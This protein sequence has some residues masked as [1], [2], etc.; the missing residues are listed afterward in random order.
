[1]AGNTD[2]DRTAGTPILRAE[3]YPIS[4]KYLK[5][6]T[7][8]IGG[9]EDAAHYL[10]L[11]LIGDDGATGAAEVICKPAWNGVTQGVLVKMFEEMAWPALVQEGLKNAHAGAAIAARF[12]GATAL[13]S[14]LDNACRDLY[15]AQAGE[16][17]APGGSWIAAAVLLTRDTPANMAGSAAK[18]VHELGYRAV[19]IK[20]GQGVETD[21]EVFSQIRQAVGG[22]IRLSID[23][24][25]AYS[26]EDAIRLAEI[27]QQIGAIFLED[28]CALVPSN[29]F[30][31][32]LNA[33]P[34]AIL[35]D[36]SCASIEQAQSFSDL[37]ASYFSAKPNR[38]GRREAEK[39]A[40]LA[41]AKGG[42]ICVGM[43]GESAAGAVTQLQLAS[44]FCAAQDALETEAGFH[45]DLSDNYLIEPLEFADGRFKLPPKKLAE[46]IDWA[47]LAAM[48]H[49]VIALDDGGN[50]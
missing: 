34:L 7:W 19:K 9:E 39:I 26:Q 24:N 33:S 46:L 23:A 37:G 17:Y 40:Q 41:S 15:S 10:V 48:S 30:R 1:M 28:P 12:R 42:K 35:V 25:S 38:I 45:L 21:R 18:A 14:L 22:D 20:A 49:G 36:K 6:V 27:A 43:F 44:T 50:S 5:P 47:K 3:L 11:K 32:L 8:T 13:Q 4:I 29:R 16:G 31:D 2:V